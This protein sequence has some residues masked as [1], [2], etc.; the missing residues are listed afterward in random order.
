MKDQ[1]LFKATVLWQ[2]DG[3]LAAITEGGMVWPLTDCFFIQV[4]CLLYIQQAG[5]YKMGH[6]LHCFLP[7]FCQQL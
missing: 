6:H 3:P 5:V 1:T 7:V 4:V 2:Q